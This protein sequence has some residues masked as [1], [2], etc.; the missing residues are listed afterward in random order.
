MLESYRSEGNLR[1]ISDHI[2]WL[3]LQL[4][5]LGNLLPHL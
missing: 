2:V 1:S 4:E 3:K 5:N